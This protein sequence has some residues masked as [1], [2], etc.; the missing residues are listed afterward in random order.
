MD[1]PVQRGSRAL[2]AKAERQAA[3]VQAVR[4]QAHPGQDSDNQR[5]AISRQGAVPPG[6]GAR[7]HGHGTQPGP[8][9]WDSFSAAGRDRRSG[10]HLPYRGLARTCCAG[11]GLCRAPPQRPWLPHPL[12]ASAME[13]V[14]QPRGR[15]R[16]F[17]HCRSGGLADQSPAHRPHALPQD[18]QIF[19]CARAAEYAVHSQCAA[20]LLWIRRMDQP[21]LV[22]GL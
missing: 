1:P 19:E 5:H 7:T 4:R 11:A 3:P 16:R 14:G 12:G 21:D 20:E 2:H 8:L 9:L 22:T 6:A 13:R 10:G 17:C 15:G 18:R